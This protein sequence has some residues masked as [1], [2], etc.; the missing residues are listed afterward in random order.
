MA[1]NV[2]FIISANFTGTQ[3]V[4]SG[5]NSTDQF[6]N[7]NWV[8]HNANIIVKIVADF[9]FITV[10]GN[11]IFSTND[12]GYSTLNKG[13]VTDLSDYTETFSGNL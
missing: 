12:V 7:G 8:A 13:A 4:L 6:K 5:F 11:V 10:E 2:E 9:V 3:I 1:R